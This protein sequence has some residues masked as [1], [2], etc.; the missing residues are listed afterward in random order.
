MVVS[1]KFVPLVLYTPKKNQSRD[2]PFLRTP[3]AGYEAPVPGFFEL[4]SPGKSPPS[5]PLNM[6]CSP[7]WYITIC[8]EYSMLGGL[9][10]RG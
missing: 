5:T 1:V 7:L 2:C 3:Y 10:D 8:W 6:K 9:S 4:E